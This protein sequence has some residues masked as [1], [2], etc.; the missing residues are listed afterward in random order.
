VTEKIKSLAG[1]PHFLLRAVLL[2][3][4]GGVGVTDAA[5]S[6]SGIE[7]IVTSYLPDF[8]KHHP[9]LAV[10]IAG[11]FGHYLAKAKPPVK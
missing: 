2:M 7:P 5:T 1:D 3:L 8:V 9:F 6:L 4:C 11:V 10:T